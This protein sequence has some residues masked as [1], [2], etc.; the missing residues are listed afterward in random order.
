ME[1]D[2]KT[3]AERV[4]EL[5]AGLA[6]SL[7]EQAAAIDSVSVKL[8]NDLSDEQTEELVRVLITSSVGALEIFKATLVNNLLELMEDALRYKRALDKLRSPSVAT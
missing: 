6:T 2:P 5:L 1:H 7:R 3:H 8:Q 4:K